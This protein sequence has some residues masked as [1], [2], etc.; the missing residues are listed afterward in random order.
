MSWALLVSSKVRS[1]ANAGVWLQR[2]LGQLA[3]QIGRTVKAVLHIPGHGPF[4]ERPNA[5]DRDGN[6]AIDDATAAVWR[7]R[8]LESSST[9]GAVLES[10]GRDIPLD[11]ALF[12]PEYAFFDEGGS[13]AGEDSPYR[14]WHVAV[15][16]N[17]KDGDGAVVMFFA[18]DEGEF[19][20]LLLFGLSSAKL[21]AVVDLP[22][23]FGRTGKFVSS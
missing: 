16:M 6:A 14:R 8:D 3:E 9:T 1:L 5:K 17:A 20:Q 4:D 7:G 21:L 10:H 18:L 2:I 23:T 15:G 11:V 13:G 22:K 19:A 12:L